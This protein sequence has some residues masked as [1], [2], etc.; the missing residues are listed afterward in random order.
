MAVGLT[1]NLGDYQSLRVD[2]GLERESDSKYLEEEFDTMQKE[3]TDQLEKSVGHFEKS[4][5]AI[6]GRDKRR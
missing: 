3:L 5:R 2:V 1:V 4:T 6:T